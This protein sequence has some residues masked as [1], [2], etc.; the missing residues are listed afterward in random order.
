MV[1]LRTAL[2]PLGEE[3]FGL[4]G[5]SVAETVVRCGKATASTTGITHVETSRL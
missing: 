5:L 2:A 4:A 3:S 1:K